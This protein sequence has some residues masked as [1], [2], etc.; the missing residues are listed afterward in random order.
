MW[1]FVLCPTL[2]T[3]MLYRVYHDKCNAY[4][5]LLWPSEIVEGKK[6]VLIL[7]EDEFRQGRNR[8]SKEGKDE[9]G[10]RPGW[11]LITGPYWL[12]K[13]DNKLGVGS[14][15]ETEWRVLGWLV[16]ETTQDRIHRLRVTK[17]WESREHGRTG[18]SRVRWSNWEKR[19]GGS[20]D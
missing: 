4:Q 14:C 20:E 1:P 2:Y 18:K 9:G 15:T 6:Q 7:Q 17:P 3:Y 16:M 11:K 13:T 5:D 12:R 8:T 19:R 10:K